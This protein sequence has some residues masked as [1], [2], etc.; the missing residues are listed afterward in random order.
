MDEECQSLLAEATTHVFSPSRKRDTQLLPCHP[1]RFLKELPADLV[2]TE[3][4]K[5]PVDHATG[6][7][8]STS[9]A[10]P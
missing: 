10:A 8:C 5:K 7:K 4:N 3:E 1:S 6:K 2:E 9:S